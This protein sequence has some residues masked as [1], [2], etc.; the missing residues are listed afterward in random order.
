MTNKISEELRITREDLEKLGITEEMLQ[1]ILTDPSEI[2]G[3]Y[4]KFD[5]AVEWFNELVKTSPLWRESLWE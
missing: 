2:P 1:P 3:S 4:M 5:E